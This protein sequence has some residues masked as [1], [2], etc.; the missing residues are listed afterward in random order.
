MS[1]NARKAAVEKFSLE[2]M[3]DRYEALFVEPDDGNRKG[4]SGVPGWYVE[5]GFQF[6]RKRMR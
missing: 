4:K 6:L 3:I 5:A 2:T 1:L